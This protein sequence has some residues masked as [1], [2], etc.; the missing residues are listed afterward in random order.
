LLFAR[1]TIKAGVRLVPKRRLGEKKFWP[2]GG[3]Q[4]VSDTGKGRGKIP[5]G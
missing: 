2:G 5:R 3:P 4:I 1:K